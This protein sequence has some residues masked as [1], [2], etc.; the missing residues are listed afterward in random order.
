MEVTI[1]CFNLP[2][3]VWKKKVNKSQDL[4]VSHEESILPASGSLKRHLFKVIPIETRLEL[5]FYIILCNKM[6]KIF[7]DY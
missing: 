5:T 2:A 3:A 7:P 1:I 6:S 4:I